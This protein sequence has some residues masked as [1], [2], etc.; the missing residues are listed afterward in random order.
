MKKPKHI[1]DKINAYQKAVEASQLGRQSAIDRAA[2][3][4]AE[5]AAV[6]AELDK[7]MS[8]TLANPTAANEAAET[9]LRKR[10]ADIEMM[11]TGARDRSRYAGMG[12]TAEQREIAID[13]IKA[14]REYVLDEW[15]KGKPEKLQAIADAKQAYLKAIADYGEYQRGLTDVFMSTGR[16]TNANYVNQAGGT[17]NLADPA[18]GYRDH[19]MADGHLYSVTESDMNK[20]LRGEL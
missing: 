3:L 12:A 17:P 6:R 1:I 20:A 16:E 5:S 8:V 4:E 11:L 19:E 2:E 15:K 10:L 7:A 14:A 13:A 9:K 18:W